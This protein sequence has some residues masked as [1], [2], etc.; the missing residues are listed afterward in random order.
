[1]PKLLSLGE[2][3]RVLE[4]LLR[5]RVSIRDLGSILEAL[6]E[7]APVNKS[8]VALVEAVAPGAGRQA[9]AAAA[10]RRGPAAGAAA[11]SRRS[12]KRF[13]PRLSPEA[14]QRL[15]AGQ[16]GAGHARGAPPRRFCEAT[17]RLRLLPRPCPCSLSK[18]GALSRQAL[19]GAGAAPAG[20]GGCRERF[21]PRSGCARWERCGEL[22]QAAKASFSEV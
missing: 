13:S 20:G 6:L 8:L 16:T 17:Y 4:Q 21:P 22:L 10:R 7:T 12:K 3:G 14:G 11:R 2:V 18:S 9:G 1:M 5:E 19:A 15:L